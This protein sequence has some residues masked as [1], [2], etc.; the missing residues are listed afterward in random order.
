MLWIDDYGK[1][2]EYLKKNHFLA[3][4][5]VVDRCAE[6]QNSWCE[7]LDTDSGYQASLDLIFYILIDTD[8]C[9]YQAGFLFY[10]L[11]TLKPVEYQASL[12][13]LTGRKFIFYICKTLKPK[14]Q[15]YILYKASLYSLTGESRRRLCR[16]FRLG[17][18]Q[19]H[20]LLQRV[21]FNVKGQN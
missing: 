21:S 11:K 16:K 14:R 9:K 4:S 3:A 6:S 19:G 5:A 1:Y 20:F 18:E 7:G 15:V 10:I 17:E 8:N 2:G 12:Y 13:S